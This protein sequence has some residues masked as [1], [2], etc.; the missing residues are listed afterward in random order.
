LLAGSIWRFHDHAKSLAVHGL[1]S[2]HRESLRMTK[3]HTDPSAFDETFS[4]T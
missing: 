1:P 2:D 3:V 4:A